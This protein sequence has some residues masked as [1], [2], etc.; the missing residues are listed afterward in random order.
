MPEP[1]LQIEH[2]DAYYGKSHIL[3]GIDL[4]VGRGEL[5]VVVGRNGMGKT[6]LLK[7]VLGLPPLVRTGTIFFDEQET[8]KKPTYEIANLGIGYVPQGRMLFPSLTVDEHLRFAWRRGG[9]SSQWSPDTVYDLFPEIKERAHISGTL[10]SGGE[11]QMLAIGRALVTNPLL[12]MMDEPSEGL[13]ISVIQR[14]EGV[15]RHLSAGGMSILLIEQNL[16]MA[17][18]LAHHAYVFMNGRIARDLTAAALSANRLLLQQLLGATAGEGV[19]EAEQPEKPEAEGAFEEPAAGEISGTVVG[20]VAPT[21]W[22]GAAFPEARAPEGASVPP[23]AGETRAGALR[24]TV[25][26]TLYQAAYIAGTFDTKARDLLFIKSCLDRQRIRT[27]TVDL[28]TS[29]KP[30]P[31]SISP[32]EVARRHPKGIGA[33][34]TGDRGSAVAGMAEAFTRFMAGRRDVG[35]IISAGGSGGTALVTPAM[36]SL[37]VGIPKVMVSTVASGNVRQYVGPSD[38][39]MMYSVT[40]V[41][42]INR[43]SASVLSNAAHAL[44]GMI[45]FRQEVDRSRLPAIGLTMFGVTTPCVQAVTKALQTRYDC[46]VFHATGTGG[47]SMEKLADSGMLE[48]I[49]DVTTTEVADYV[50]GGVMSA[51]EDRMGAIIR[52]KIPYVGS[53]GALDM[54]NFE[55]IDTVPPQF[56]SRNLYQHNPQVTLMRT[57]VEENRA[58][59]RFI[60]GKLNRMEGPVRFLL[61]LKGVSSIDAPGKP[62]H[63][64]AADRALFDTLE[65]EFRPAPNRRMIKLDMNINDPPF[66][67]ALVDHFLD[68]MPSGAAG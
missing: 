38:I 12:L 14:V 3:Q 11:Q 37:P 65:S 10:L 62:F 21:L 61:P 5:V 47:Q 29:R 9:A 15:C 33:V 55:A 51:G 40:D 30:S 27:I 32:T 42:G 26:D 41:A 52:T 56:K 59:A 58:F 64:P 50:V 44:A 46:L 16:E 4:Q 25:A 6:T 60:A 7:S 67:E 39:C 22:S 31:A 18:S 20:A 23:P 8:V 28:S 1:L 66:A 63:D 36:R 57:T 68:I 2:L 49:I 34:F 48:G 35:G 43:I 45:G 17:H 53:C 24:V 54:V 19:L 13:S